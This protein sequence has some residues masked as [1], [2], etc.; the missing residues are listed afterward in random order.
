MY[1]YKENWI[2]LPLKTGNNFREIGGYPGEDGK[3]IQWHRFV[4]ASSTSRLS[5]EDIEFLKGYGVV[6]DI[7]LRSPEEAEG[8]KDLLA[9]MDWVDYRI[10]SLSG[11]REV[12]TDNLAYQSLTLSIAKLYVR[13][14]I[15][16]HD[17]IRSIFEYI[18]HAPKGCIL[19]HCHAGKDRT[20][21]LAMLLMYLAGADHE[22]CM[23]NY[24]Q[25][26]S[27]LRRGNLR[28]HL[29][30]SEDEDYA[31]FLFS[32]PDTILQCLRYIDA[33]YAGVFPYLLDCGISEADILKVK[34]RLLDEDYT[35]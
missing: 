25:S 21:I 6:A 2:R 8:S 26:Y 3:M 16:Q 22:D 11:C 35:V 12:H 33:K 29:V 24:E 28:S 13:D 17:A 20:G 5:G 14:M 31:E 4:R 10:L 34:S 9:G 30:N 32:R 1:N 23:T 7:D 18:A 27:N 15:E 19:F